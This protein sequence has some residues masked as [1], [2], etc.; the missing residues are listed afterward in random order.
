MFFLLS[1]I[2]FAVAIL[3]TVPDPYMSNKKNWGI[4][5]WLGLAGVASFGIGIGA[6]F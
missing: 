4:A 5:V 2:L 3:L 1:A 6:L